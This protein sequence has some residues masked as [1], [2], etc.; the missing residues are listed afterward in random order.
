MSTLF[1]GF[2]EDEWAAS[3]RR[4][5]P[6]QE[7]AAEARVLFAAIEASG[8]NGYAL[9]V[10]T[11]ALLASLSA[12]AANRVAQTLAHH[13]E[14]YRTEILDR[15]ARLTANEPDSVRTQILAALAKPPG[16]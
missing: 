15:V 1:V 7:A 8:S 3:L 13:S 14:N 6:A 5:M 9:E 11:W 2:S 4:I 16:S 12:D 10:E